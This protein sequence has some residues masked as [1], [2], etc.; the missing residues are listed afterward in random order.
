MHKRESVI[1]NAGVVEA[2]MR[3]ALSMPKYEYQQDS[4]SGQPVNVQKKPIERQNN[5]P[6]KSLASLNFSRA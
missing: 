4:K 5:K 6:I 1:R 2:E 3:R